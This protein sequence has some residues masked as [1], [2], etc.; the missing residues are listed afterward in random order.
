MMFHST[1]A[2]VQWTVTSLSLA[3]VMLRMLPRF[4]LDRSPYVYWERCADFRSGGPRC[5]DV[6]LVALLAFPAQ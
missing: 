6:R 5:F 1:E 2:V 4:P 3:W